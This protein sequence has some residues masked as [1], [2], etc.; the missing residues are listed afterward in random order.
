M[1]KIHVVK[2]VILKKN[3]EVLISKRKKY[4][5]QGGLWEFPGGKVETGES[6]IDALTR[7]LREELAISVINPTPFL[8]FNYNYPEIEIY[9][10][11]WM[12]KKFSGGAKGN[13]GQ[14][15]AWVPI[16]N[17]TSYKFP[18]ANDCILDKIKMI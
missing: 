3:S 15:I 12:V 6:S 7:E 14:T 18:A 5:L 8:K 11:V 16:E 1:S 13:E 9:M 4:L 10:D 17:L 2:A